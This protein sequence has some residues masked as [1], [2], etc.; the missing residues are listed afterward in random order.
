MFLRSQPA[1]SYSVATK[2]NPMA[3]QHHG[4]TDLA[5]VEAAVDASLKRLGLPCIDLYYAHRMPPT[6]EGLLEWMRACKTLVAKGK[7][8]SVGLSEVS[9]SWLREAHKVHPVAAIQ[10]EWSLFSRSIEEHLAPVCKELKVAI[11]A[12]SPLARNLLAQPQEEVLAGDWRAMHP[13]FTAENRKRNGELT[14]LIAVMAKAKGKSAAQL[15]L[16]WLYCRA[17]QL[18]VTV[19]PIPGTTKL[20]HAMDNW[21]ALDIKL[22]AAE[23][24]KLEELGKLVAGPRGDERYMKVSFEQRL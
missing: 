11:V 12:Y 2:F 18:G 1:G 16:G 13:R 21:G 23:M 8:K 14:A 10:M 22:S 15:S 3:P 6:L 17:E 24:L 9:P 4:K 7:I 20:E 19:V 5:T